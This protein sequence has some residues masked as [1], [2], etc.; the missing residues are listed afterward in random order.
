ML[1]VSV[2]E[3]IPMAKRYGQPKYFVLGALLSAIVY[4]LLAALTLGRLTR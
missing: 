2:H 3:L 4:F 1:F